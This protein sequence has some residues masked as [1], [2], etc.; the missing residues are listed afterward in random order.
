MRVY[1]VV[2]GVLLTAGS[3]YVAQ[4]AV[5]SAGFE[6]LPGLSQERGDHQARGEVWYGGMLAPITIEAARPAM[7]SLALGV[8][9]V[10]ANDPAT[11]P[12]AVACPEVPRP[13]R[14]AI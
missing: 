9:E 3:A 1:A 13:R 5:A 4:L 12:K 7:P 8:A 14:H 11:S 6:R 10:S 2:L